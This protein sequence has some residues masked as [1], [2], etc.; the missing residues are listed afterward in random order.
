MDRLG[1]ITW[2]HNMSVNIQGPGRIELSPLEC[3]PRV[4]QCV[5]RLVI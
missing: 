1:P 4:E 5:D 2:T 3:S